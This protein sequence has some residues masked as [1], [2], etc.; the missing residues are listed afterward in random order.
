MEVEEPGQA[1][2]QIGRGQERVVDDSTVIEEEANHLQQSTFRTLDSQ[3]IE[4]AHLP[5]G[6]LVLHV[7]S[8]DS[9]E[10]LEKIIRRDLAEPRRRLEPRAR[11][12]DGAW[13]ATAE[14]RG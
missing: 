2:E 10:A 7:Q 14:E 1:E 12:L 9:L 5:F 11:A 3:R 8:L 13:L 4:L 6:E